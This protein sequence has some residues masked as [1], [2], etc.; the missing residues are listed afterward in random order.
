MVEGEDLDLSPQSVAVAVDPNFLN[1]L[2]TCRLFHYCGN[3]CVLDAPLEK[4][5]SHSIT[6]FCLLDDMV[7]GFYNRGCQAYKV[8]DLFLNWMSSYADFDQELEVQ[9]LV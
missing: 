7:I 6:L 2:P 4:G 3:F 1:V 9:L 5:F 8:L